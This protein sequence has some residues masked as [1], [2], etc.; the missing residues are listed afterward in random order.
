MLSPAEKLL[1]STVRITTFAR[2]VT[3]Q[4]GTGFFF[5]IPV[6]SGNI[7]VL[8]TN[9][10]VI[11]GADAIRLQLNLQKVDAQEPSG[12]II[13]INNRVADDGVVVHPNPSVDLCALGT[14]ELVN[15]GVAAGRSVFVVATDE[16]II[17]TAD[18]WAELD[19][20]EPIVMIGCPQGLYDEQNGLAIMRRGITASHPSF[21]YNGRDE[22]MIDAAC[23]PG[24][25][26]SPVFLFDQST[27][28]DKKIGSFTMGGV[29]LKLLGILF[30]GPT[31]TQEGAIVLAKI[32]KIEVTGMM[33]L[34]NVIRSTRLVELKDEIVKRMGL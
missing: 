10:H 6:S 27:R 31:I 30:E 26:G 3:L 34:G 12:E 22:F 9:K 17:P 8:V 18:E 11:A 19:A 5:H 13:T 28:F 33:H 2:N 32:P 1:Y 7:V 24:S 21:K 15:P 29:K 25:S 16:N 20:M 14:G 23:F 4:Y